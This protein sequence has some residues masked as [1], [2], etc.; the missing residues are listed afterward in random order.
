MF[1]KAKSL[2]NEGRTQ[3]E[4]KREEKR[5][6]VCDRGEQR[7]IYEIEL[8]FFSFFAKFNP[9]DFSNIENLVRGNKKW[10]E[11]ISFSLARRIVEELLPSFLAKRERK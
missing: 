3:Q 11:K 4:S 2:G 1:S 7:L 6:F 8:N 5:G 10:N 9:G